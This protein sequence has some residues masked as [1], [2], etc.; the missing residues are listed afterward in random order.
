MS[1]NI[2][3]FLLSI[4]LL[5]GILVT[6]SNHWHNDFHF[7]DAHTVQ[8]NVYIQHL[9]NIPLFYK[10]PTTFSS[11]P[12]HCSY[13]PLVSTTLAIDYA[14]G[15]GLDPFWFH[16]DT[17]I[18]FLLQGVLMFFMF[19][20]ML[21]VV[22]NN[23]PNKYIA[24]FATALYMLH[25]SLAETVNYIISRSDTLSTLF[26]VMSFVVYQYSAIARK[27]FLYLIPMLIGC[28]AKPTAIMFA[29]MLIV[30]H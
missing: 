7:D 8:S 20:K 14:M 30:Y 23:T 9:N 19:L 10:D 25:P 21:D 26:V 3:V 1:D 5:L 2:K 27:Y 11:M 17:F 24:L 6:Y 18:L 16:L 29:P 12:S 13:R 22:S 4:V 15:K 28:L